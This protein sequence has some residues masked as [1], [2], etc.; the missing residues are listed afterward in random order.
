MSIEQIRDLDKLHW[1]VE[2]K[3]K[4]LIENCKK[5]GIIIFVTETV[6]TNERQKW[7][8]EQGRSRPGNI[9][10]NVSKPSF[11]AEHLGLAFDIAILING[12]VVWDNYD[13]WKIVGEEGVK[14]GFTWGGNWKTIRDMPHFQL[15]DGLKTSDIRKG[16][17]PTWFYNKKEK[18]ETK[19]WAYQ[20]Y[21]YL[22]KNGVKIHDKRFDDPITR[23]E[24][25]VL[26]AR[27]FKAI[28]EVIKNGSN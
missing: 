4:Q 7:L 28:M 16:K 17:L 15:D 21:D 8:Y 10:T 11:H 6:R 13:A 26:I 3:C 24:V 23:G 12:K 18:D 5:R 20:Y 14:L 1:M 2:E 9:V 25:I 27:V 19:H 22:T